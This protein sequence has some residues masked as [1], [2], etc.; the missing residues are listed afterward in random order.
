MQGV[1]G[2]KIL[3][4]HA[5]VWVAGW[6]EP[7]CERALGATKRDGYDFIEVPLLDPARV[8]GAMTRKKLANYGLSASCSLGLGF[9]TDISSPDPDVA[10]R[11]EALLL[12]GLD[13]TAALGANYLGGVLYSA[14]GKYRAPAAAGTLER[15]AAVLRR[16]AHRARNVDITIGP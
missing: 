4:V 15:V 5:S 9:G 12:E 13:V 1:A 11:G 3:E 8:D 6:S 10:Q 16:L 2:Q 7:E 14:M